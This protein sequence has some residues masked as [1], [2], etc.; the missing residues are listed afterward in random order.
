MHMTTML[1][2]PTSPTEGI[3]RY[4]D[5]PAVGTTDAEVR[6]DPRDAGTISGGI[7]TSQRRS[8][9]IPPSDSIMHMMTML[10]LPTSPTEGI[11]RYSDQP[12]V[13]TT[14]AQVRLDPRDAGT[15]SGGIATS[16]RRSHLYTTI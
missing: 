6:L 13:G 2:L 5:Q 9:H 11:L 15:I 8:H 3:L 4:S 16:Q 14:D 10:D 7:A 12:A 1:D